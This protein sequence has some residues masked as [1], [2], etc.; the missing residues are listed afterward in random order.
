MY[1]APGIA[2]VALILSK[3]SSARQGDWPLVVPLQALVFQA[4]GA[5]SIVSAHCVPDGGFQKDP[6]RFVACALHGQAPRT[7]V[8][9]SLLYLLCRAGRI[10][11][12]IGSGGSCAARA[13]QDDCEDVTCGT[14][15]ISLACSHTVLLRFLFVSC[16]EFG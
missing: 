4:D 8:R 2:I 10:G 5:G 9:S 3:S 15:G 12:A 16:L 6:N 7:L 14:R 13:L 11:C 1:V